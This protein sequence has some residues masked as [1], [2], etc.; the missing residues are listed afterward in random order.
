MYLIAAISDNSVVGLGDR[1]PWSLPHDL[2]WFKMH[3]TGSVV[4][5]GRKT[6][7][8]LPRKP[9]PGRVHIILSRDHHHCENNIFWCTSMADAIRIADGFG[10]RVF[11]IGGPDIWGQA[12]L[13]GHVTHAIL[14]RVH[15]TVQRYDA[16]YMPLPPMVTLW[17]SRM[18]RRRQLEYHFEIAQVHRRRAPPRPRLQDDL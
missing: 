9:L 1:L 2:A 8:S 4:I 17:T 14:T 18:F 5:M 7:D 12:L 13:S 3:T 10:R 16:V 11:V 6:W 15:T